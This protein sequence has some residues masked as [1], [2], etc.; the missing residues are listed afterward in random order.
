MKHLAILTTVAMLIVLVC[1]GCAIGLAGARVSLATPFSDPNFS[2]DSV[3]VA[4][5]NAHAAGAQFSGPGGTAAQA[6]PDTLAGQAD[7]IVVVGNDASNA[8]STDT[9][10]ADE[11]SVVGGRETGAVDASGD[12]RLDRRVTPTVNV[13]P[14]GGASVDASDN[15]PDPV[16]VDGDDGA[17]LGP[18]KH[19]GGHVLGGHRWRACPGP[20]CTYAGSHMP[21]DYA[22]PASGIV[23]AEDLTAI[24]W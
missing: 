1:G 6:D 13:G 18:P 17:S 2:Y 3:G 23:D 8:R 9:G 10:M 24:L 14:G 5:K 11:Q 12:R 22:P 19:P 15:V 20:G 4:Q 7:Q 16:P 21:D